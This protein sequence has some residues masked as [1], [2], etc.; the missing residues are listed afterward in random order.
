MFHLHFEV[1]NGRVIKPV[2]CTQSHVQVFFG[3]QGRRQDT[4]Q[5]V[6][7]VVTLRSAPVHCKHQLLLLATEDAEITD[8]PEQPG[9]VKP[10]TL[11]IVPGVR[12]PVEDVDAIRTLLPVITG[13][14]TCQ[15][16]RNR[17]VLTRSAIETGVDIDPPGSGQFPELANLNIHHTA[18][19]DDEIH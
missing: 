14:P 9:H 2:I 11:T 5:P 8:L 1:Q 18:A 7:V 4:M 15:G 13:Q 12:K 6:V 3:G 19:E 16:C 17:T 10:V